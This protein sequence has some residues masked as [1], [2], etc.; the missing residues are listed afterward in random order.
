MKL[1]KSFLVCALLPR[2]GLKM[3]WMV[4]QQQ[5]GLRQKVT[6]G[7][8]LYPHLLPYKITKGYN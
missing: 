1:N 7:S 5:S 3:V 2:H 6:L 8:S 4:F